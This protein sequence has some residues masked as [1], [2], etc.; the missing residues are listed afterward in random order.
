MSEFTPKDIFQG[1]VSAF[2]KYNE[3]P[4]VSW[5]Y[6]EKPMWELILKRF[7]RSNLSKAVIF[8][9]GSG[10][11]N[12]IDM[13]F[14]AGADPRQIF[15]LEPNPVLAAL[16]S[17][18]YH[19]REV[20]C[21][22]DSSHNMGDD[23][24]QHGEYDL[25]T[26]NM[27]VNHLTTSEYEDLVKCVKGMLMLGGIFIY[28]TP[29]PEEK[30]KKHSFDCS[31]NSVV[32]DELAPWGGMVKYHHRSEEYQVGLL[33]ANGFEV[34]RYFWGYDDFLTSFDIERGENALGK[35]L[36]GPKRLLVLAQKIK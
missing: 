7:K 5:E 30:A 20:G 16:L 4:Q 10:T 25:V 34:E 26:A 17:N 8:D 15:A 18:K 22:V 27:V 14:D 24:L 1:S 23:I 32:V 9:I 13:L 6:L 19:D 12:S 35:S 31:D 29:F 11:G 33:E 21:I 3:R 2:I 28:T 36:K